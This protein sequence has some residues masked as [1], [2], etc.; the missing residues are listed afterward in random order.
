MRRGAEHRDDV[1][2]RAVAQRIMHDVK[3]RAAP[4]HDAV[5]RHVGLELRHRH[6]GAVRGI[7]DRMR[8]AVADELAAKQRA[9][10][11]GGDDG[12]AGKRAAVRG[13]QRDALAAILETRDHG[14]GDQLD[15]IVAPAGVEQ[16]V[17]HVDAMNDDVGM[18]EARAERRCGRNAHDLLA[19]E[20]VEHQQR[21]R[22]IRNGKHLLAQA[23]AVEDVKDVGPELDAVADGA[24]F[25]RAFEHA[26]GAAAPR[27]R[28][29]RGEA[30]EPAAD[31]QDGIAVRHG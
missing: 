10:T 5:A 4:Q 11:V 30:A 17:M 31:D 19:V 2:Q 7:A 8:F 6:D 15:R 29:R 16:D 9:Q 24:E 3:A 21:G 13:R 12:G 22:R 23:E 18:L 1:E 27:Q 20:R 28:Q 26:R 14:V 25:R